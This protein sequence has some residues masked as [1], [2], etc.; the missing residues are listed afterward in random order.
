M[1]VLNYRFIV[2]TRNSSKWIEGFLV[3]YRRL[4]VEPLYLLDRR[5]VDDTEAI[6]ASM[7]ADYVLVSSRHS[8]VESIIAECVG[9]LS[10]KWVIR[11]DDDEIPS[12]QMAE[13]IDKNILSV[14]SPSISFSRRDAFLRGNDLFY[15]RN[16]AYYWLPDNYDYLNPQ[17]RAFQPSWTPA[18][19]G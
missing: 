16:E 11:L 5:S 1:S 9:L 18:K 6:L 7:K 8:R 12:R 10:E 15:S 13:W 3:E 4:G 14:E 19:T 2:P 17:W